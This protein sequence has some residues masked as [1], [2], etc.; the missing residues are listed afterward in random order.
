M[1]AF[2]F[3]DDARAI[4][5]LVARDT[6][7][8]PSHT[9]GEFDFDRTITKGK[10][11]RALDSLCA[12]DSIDDV[13]FRKIRSGSRTVNVLAEI[14]SQS[15]QLSFAFHLGLR[16]PAQNDESHST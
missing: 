6:N 1:C 2:V 9:L 3:V 5:L 15:K 12:K 4:R 16:G 11:V 10:Q 7:S 8:Q 13:L 14:G